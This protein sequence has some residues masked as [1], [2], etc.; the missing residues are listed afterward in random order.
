M[1]LLPASATNTFRLPSTAT[2]RGAANCPFPE[3]NVPQM[4]RN[5]PPLSNFWMWSLVV[6][7]TNTLPLPSTATPLGESNCPFTEPPVPQ[8]ARH[9]LPLL[10]LWM[11]HLS[12]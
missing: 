11:R 6:S 4:V 3:P 5:V 1:R 9:V 10:T 7:A 8:V 12:D 2:P